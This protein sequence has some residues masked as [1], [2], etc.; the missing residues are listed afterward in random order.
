MKKIPRPGEFYRHFKN[1]LYQVLAVAEHTETGES[2]VIYQAL[3]GSFRIY[4][5]PLELFMGEVDWEKYPDASQRY[6]FE[7]VKLGEGMEIKEAEGEKE[8][9][10]AGF[11]ELFLEAGTAAEKLAVLNSR[12]EE[13]SQAQLDMICEAMEIPCRAGEKSLEAV[14]SYLKTQMKY[15]GNRLRR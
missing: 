12:G 1:K 14:R 8:E 15:D 4:A 3:Y 6:R 7:Q 2:L 9:K 11:L 5:R 10:A 13:A